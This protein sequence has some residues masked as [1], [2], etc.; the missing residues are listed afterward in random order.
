MDYAIFSLL[1]SSTVLMPSL[2]KMRYFF[3]FFF[4]SRLLLYAGHQAGAGI[5]RLF[6]TR[7]QADTSGKW[8]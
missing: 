5:S 7:P 2:F 6:C 8:M 4:K 3:Y 1:V